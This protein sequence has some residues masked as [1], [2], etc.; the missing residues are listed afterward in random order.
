MPMFNKAE[1]AVFDWY[2]ILP[3]QKTDLVKCA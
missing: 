3:P 1:L 2:A